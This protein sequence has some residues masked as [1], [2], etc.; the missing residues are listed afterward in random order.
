MNT[1]HIPKVLS[2]LFNEQDD[3]LYRTLGM[4]SVS[5]GRLREQE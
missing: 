3:V 1:M 4:E 2:V 5:L